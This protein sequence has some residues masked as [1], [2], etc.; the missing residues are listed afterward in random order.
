MDVLENLPDEYLLLLLL[1]TIS[2]SG[3]SMARR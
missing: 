2:H 1:R 3:A